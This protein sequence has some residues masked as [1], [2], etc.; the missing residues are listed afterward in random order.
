MLFRSGSFLLTYER[1]VELL[2]YGALIAFMGVNAAALA[3][4]FLRVDHESVG[5]LLRNALSNLIPPLLGFVICFFLWLNL[6][7]S[8]KIV[9]SIWMLAGILFGIWKTRGFREQLSFEVPPE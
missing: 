4:Y 6:S 2:N 1:G 5:E 3:R 8:A 7:R 9:G